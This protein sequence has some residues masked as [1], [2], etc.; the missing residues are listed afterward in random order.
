MGQVRIV[1]ASAG[2]GKTYRLAY[3]YVKKVIR[4]PDLYRSILAVTFTNK[5]TEEMKRQNVGEI[6]ALAQGNKKSGEKPEYLDQLIRET[7]YNAPQ[8]RGRAEKVRT[9]ILHD[10]SHFTVLT[11][12]KFFQR[13]IRA[14]IRELGMEADFTL[15]LQ[16]DS[17][18]G[19]AVD[20]LIEETATD[21]ELQ[22]WIEGFVG[23][24]IAEGK[25]W[26]IRGEINS[27][28]REIFKEH[29]R[30][31][32][33]PAEAREEIR[34]LIGEYTRTLEKIKKQMTELAGRAVRTIEEGG[35]SVA[36]FSYGKSGIA[37]W[38]YAVASGEVWKGYGKRVADALTLP[39]GK[40][41]GKGCAR[42]GELERLVPELRQILIRLC[43]L[44][45][46]N[47]RFAHTVLLL[48]ENFRTFA[49]LSDLSDQVR[50]MCRNRNIM[51]ISDTN[52]IINDLVAHN[53][54][55]FIFEK[56]GN[57]FSHYMID[58]FQDTSLSQ[59]NNF[60]PL[61]DNALAQSAEDP[62]LIVGDVKQSIYR[63]RGGDWRILGRRI[64]ERFPEVEQMVLD[65][66]FRSTGNIVAFNNEMISAVV[67]ADNCW[68]NDQLEEACRTGRI[69]PQEKEELADTLADAYADCRQ[70]SARKNSE[71][72]G[73]IRLVQYL[74]DAQAEEAPNLTLLIRTIEELQKRGFPAGGIAV[75]V[76]T[77]R[78]AEEVARVLMAHK[79]AHP[80][81]PFCFDMV[82]QE[83]LRIG[84]S[85]AV[86]FLA[87]C[88][89]LSIDPE[90]S[91]SRA[92]VLKYTGRPPGA[93]L[94]E[95]EKDFFFSLRLV[96]PE[97]AFE[98]I[99]VRYRPDRDAG[100]IAF[101]QAFHDQVITFS[102]TRISD[103]PLF[104]RW[105]EET[106]RNE[107]VSLPDGRNAVTIITIHKSKGLQYPAV[108]LPFADWSMMP[109]RETLLWA[110]TAMEPFA[111]L[112][113]MPVGFRKTVADSAYSPHYYREMVYSHVDNVN[114]LYVALTRAEEELHVMMPAA[115]K[116][117]GTKISDLMR[118]A[119]RPVASGAAVGKMTG[120]SSAPDGSTVYEF[121]T[122]VVREPATEPGDGT[123]FRMKDYPSFPF[124][125]KIRLRT[126][127]D[128][129]LPDEPA[130]ASPRRYGQLMH[131]VFES[132]RTAEEIPGVLDRFGVDG[133]IS[134][135]ERERIQGMIV[136]AMDHP[137]VRDW[138]APGWEVV[139]NENDILVPGRASSTRRPDR[140]MIRG[141]QVVVVDYKF[142]S[143]EKK[144]Y[145]RQIGEYLRLIRGMGYKK[146]EGF[147]WYVELDRI[148]KVELKDDACDGTQQTFG[149]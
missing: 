116:N 76:R 69:S 28:G 94:T 40:W 101:I 143:V 22:R 93:G 10:Y 82:T 46:E 2:S 105:W 103:I 45:D 7:G 140:V 90:D 96:S 84:K 136:R 144:I 33:N 21:Q 71:N 34:A 54:T 115:V 77:N 108:I 81:T 66:N 89:R 131:R 110:D 74:K 86:L 127:S 50:R 37:A 51:L 137:S 23:E 124:G 98:K 123:V 79:S 147:L 139:R 35:F 42:K 53:D 145:A 61:L 44:Y 92:Y 129:Y 114:T 117:E 118:Q 119:I 149:F 104:L 11:I 73:F 6:H 67:E 59:W 30:M 5:A 9:R 133:V 83:A 3:E 26:D 39:E 148:E 97:E 113:R 128:R 60:I 8:I 130:A 38:F 112:G 120:T 12:D 134:P 78:E 65:R 106:G 57:H 19:T 14:F 95:E 146:V 68:L 27:L 16:T 63:W 48:R 91:V 142:G 88:F 80:D 25:S 41:P 18:L 49:I 36:D 141:D 126:P 122:P 121:G 55:P 58:E 47:S 56:T 111:R 132:V 24:R 20:Q 15:E 85:P 62:V 13:I 32:E 17:L 29:F 4:D 75:L 72:K 1:K 102:S 99:L 70:E 87:A 100:A 125:G 31:P 64:E 135:E 109:H 52:R 43:A 138:F 107:S